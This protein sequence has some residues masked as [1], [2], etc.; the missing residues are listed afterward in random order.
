MRKQILLAFFAVSIS[1][2]FELPALAQLGA[3]NDSGISVGHVHLLVK[4]PEVH[5]KAFVEALGAQVTKTGTLEL[6]R[7]PGVFII[8]TKGEPTAG[9]VGSTAD[10]IGLSVKDLADVREKLKAVGIETQGVFAAFPD[11][12]RVEFL[13]EKAQTLPVVAHHIHLSVTNG[14][15]LREWYVKTFG[16]GV[17]SRRNLPSAMFN[18]GEVDFLPA[19]MPAAPTKGRTIDHIGF[20]VKN[21]EA[22]MKKLAADGVTVDAPY[23]ELPNF[24][25]KVAFI[26]D[27]AG[28]RI[29]LTEGLV[30]K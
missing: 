11:N 14:E 26:L 18:G 30:G 13:E 24:G 22:F 8:M 7:L 9:S 4:D 2:F 6:L 20:E 21:L 28:T 10:H 1:P 5:K 16:A 25:L 12:L 19:R 3:P 29:E 27:P 17:G 15:K 23:R